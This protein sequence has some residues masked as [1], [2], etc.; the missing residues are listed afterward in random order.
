MQVEIWSDVVCPWC[1][2]GKRRFEEALSRFEGRDAVEVRY[3]PYQLDPSAPP[4][5]SMPAS[6]AYARKFGGPEQARRIIDNVTSVAAEAG[7]EFHLDRAIRAN[8]LLAHRLLW[9]A[10]QHDLAT[11]RAL[12]EALLQAYFTDGEHIG[13]PEVLVRRAASVGLDRDEVAA[14]LDSDAGHAEVMERLALAHSQGITA[15]PTYVVNGRWAVPGAQDPD[16]FLRVLERMAAVEL[17]EARACAEDGS[18]E[19]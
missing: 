7:I 15:V 6:E 19:V 10:E 2:I 5:T 9:F 11:Q 12:K 17:D 13:D 1:Y 16:T 3:M 8:T 4:G 14:F 18:C